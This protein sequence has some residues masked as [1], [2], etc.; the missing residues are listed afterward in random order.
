MAKKSKPKVKSAAA[1]KAAPKQPAKKAASKAAATKES[2]AKS[3]KKAVKKAAAKAPKKPA[4]KPKQA[5]KPAKEKAAK[6]AAAVEAV[7]PPQKPAPKK[8]S[9][10]PLPAKAVRKGRQAAINTPQAPKPKRSVRAAGLGPLQDVTVLELASSVAGQAAGMIFAS[11]GARVIKVEPPEG[12]PGRSAEPLMDGVG[13]EF[14]MLNRG[15]KS[16]ALDLTSKKGRDAVLK[17]AESVDVVIESVG[18]PGRNE[19]GGKPLT[20]ANPE[21]IY[22]AISGYGLTGAYAGRAASELNYMALAGALELLGGDSGMPSV[23]GIQLAEF[24]GGALPAVIGV[25]IA[26]HVRQSSGQG[27]I[28]DVST[29]DGLIGLLALPMADYGATRRKPRYGQEPLFGQYACYN[30][31]PAR[32]SRWLAVGALHPQHWA[33][34]CKV[35]DRADLIEDQFADGDRQQVV[36]AELT[37]AFQRKEV[38]EWMELFEGKPVCV[39][40]VRNVSDVAHDEHL[41]ERETV[42]P[43]KGPEGPVPLLGAYPKLSATPGGVHMSPPEIGADSVQVLEEAEFSQKD[44]ESLVKGKTLAVAS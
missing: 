14:R 26:L 44:I 27:Q 9:R 25:L 22:A 23:P 11:F 2:S 28:V 18:S 12:D 10:L 24:A 36:V 41:I 42:A 43:V 35:L 6:P 34:L 32:N 4:A 15:K 37:R 16:L 3:A 39:T 13:A 7:K 19:I 20:K 38:R 8:T 40:E 30:V 17:L 21:L 33:E 29:F 31:Y 5:P 1:K